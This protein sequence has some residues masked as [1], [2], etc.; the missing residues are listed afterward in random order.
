MM[1]VG[2]GVAEIRVRTRLAHRVFYVAKFAEAIYVL[3][4]FEKRTRKTPP[5]EIELARRRLGELLRRR[6]QAGTR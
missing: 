3:S 2:A 5:A 1:T 6:G 4:A